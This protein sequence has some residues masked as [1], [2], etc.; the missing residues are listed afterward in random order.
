M[1][2]LSGRDAAADDPSNQEPVRFLIRGG[3]LPA[4][5]DD[6]F[7][8]RLKFIVQASDLGLSIADIRALLRAEAES[9][10]TVAAPAVRH[11]ACP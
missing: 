9:V 8:R 3:L 10:H 5:V 7:R 6:R 2:H 1:E 11:R 4:E